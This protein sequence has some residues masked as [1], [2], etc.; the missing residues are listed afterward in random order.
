M[1]LLIRKLVKLVFQVFVLSIPRLTTMASIYLNCGFLIIELGWKSLKSEFNKESNKI[2]NYNF[3]VLR[4]PKEPN[5]Q[6]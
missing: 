1:E 5:I 6:F 2:Q 3:W 4:I